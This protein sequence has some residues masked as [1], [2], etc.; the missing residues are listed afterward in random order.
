L[1]VGADHPFKP[2]A[3][4]INYGM[5]AFRLQ[6]EARFPWLQ[7]HLKKVIQRLHVQL[8]TPQVRDVPW[9]QYL[10]GVI[11][12]F[13]LLWCG[14]AGA[15]LLFPVRRL[16]HDG[17]RGKARGNPVQEIAIDASDVVLRIQG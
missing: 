3:G 5:S 2:R 11:E 7:L 10:Q 13:S 17:Q 8:R 4:R 16:R 6:C 15:H 1:E 9:R 14:R 12:E